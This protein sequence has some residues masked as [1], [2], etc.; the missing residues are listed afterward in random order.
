M[1]DI[2]VERNNEQF[3]G[4]DYDKVGRDEHVDSFVKR[5]M[6]EGIIHR[7]FVGCIKRDLRVVFHD[8]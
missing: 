2:R 5:A 7:N 8:S 1:H 6:D 3:D 4:Y